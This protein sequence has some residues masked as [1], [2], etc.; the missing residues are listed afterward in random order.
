MQT[1]VIMALKVESQGLFEAAGYSP[2]YC[3]VGSSKATHHLT[4][5][6]YEYKP[7]R[8][9]NLGTAG[10]LRFN[11]GKL[12]ECTSFVQRQTHDF[13][14]MPF[15]NLTSEPLTELPK[16]ICG[17]ADFIETSA[18]RTKCDIFDMEAYSLA[19]VCKKMNVKFNSIK[20]VTDSSNHKVVEDWQKNLLPSAEALLN[21]L[22]ELNL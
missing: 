4:K 13:L 16:V 1:L 5:W 3:G 7:Q 9:L 11:I 19:Y 10:S 12:V 21:Q 8:V 18:P 2:F 14:K 15:E 6:I 22:N 20:Y 17:S